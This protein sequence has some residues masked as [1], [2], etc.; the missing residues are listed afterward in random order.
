[1]TTEQDELK[2]REDTN[3]SS[4]NEKTE[5]ENDYLIVNFEESKK[6]ESESKNDHF[7]DISKLTFYSHGLDVLTKSND[8][9]DPEYAQY[10]TPKLIGIDALGRENSLWRQNIPYG[11]KTA[12]VRKPALRATGGHLHGT[13]AL[14]ALRNVTGNGGTLSF[15]LIHTGIHL[16]VKPTDESDFIDLEFRL[17]QVATQVGM[18]TTGLLLSA[19]SGVFSSELIDLALSQVTSSNLQVG[20]DELIPTLRKLINP[21]DYST[22]IW[23]VLASKFI[24]GYD[25]NFE[26]ANSKCR[27]VRSSRISFARMLWYDT[28]K[29]TDKQLK[30]LVQKQSSVTVQD[31]EDYAEDFG[32]GNG[33]NFEFENGIKI[34]FKFTSLDHYLSVSKEWVSEIERQYNQAMSSYS[35]EQRR[36]QY[37]HSQIQ[38][39]RMRKYE[40]MVSEIHIPSAIEGEYNIIDKPED[41]RNLLTELSTTSQDY[42]IFEQAAINYIDA[43][44]YAIIG[45]VAHKCKKCGFEPETSKGTFRSIVPI[46]VDRVLFTLVQQ[47]NSIMT[48]LAEE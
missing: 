42:L 29:L 35:T 46:A 30:I 34:K 39:R 17:G 19:R 40:H 48:A 3:E 2:R 20:R 41:I 43:N 7:Q 9:L 8:D 25:W 45:Y 23:S 12:N 33:N 24:S 14:E 5:V 38:A 18:S 36:Q 11:E 44:T 13:A 31:V 37:L 16:T 4:S 32:E 22:L 15:P 47:R 28:S 1:M 21:L 26:C 6:I 27:D 10:F